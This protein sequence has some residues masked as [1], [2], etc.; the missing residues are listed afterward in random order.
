M[1]TEILT[2]AKNTSVMASFPGAGRDWHSKLF[3]P[4]EWLTHFLKANA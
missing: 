2:S 3:C 4:Q 1:E